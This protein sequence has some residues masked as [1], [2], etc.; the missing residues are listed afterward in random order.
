MARTLT[1]EQK[2]SLSR[3]SAMLPPGRRGVA[4]TQALGHDV[5]F[6]ADRRGSVMK[7]GVPVPETWQKRVLALFPKYL[8]VEFSD[9]HTK[10]W[11]W[12]DKI[13]IK[14]S[15]RPF[16]AVWPR[17]RGKSTH[18]E[19][20]VADLGARGARK[21]AIYVSETQ[22]QAD[23][24]IQ[25]IRAVLESQDFIKYFP[26]LGEPRVGK[27][28]SR[29]WRRSILTTDTG[30][31]VE[32]VGL[33]R[34]IRGHKIDWA[35]PD[36]ILF[37]DIDAKHDTPLSVKRKEGTIT[38]SILPSGATNCAVV[39]CQN[40]IHPDSIANK[41]SKI[42]SA[43]GSADYLA[44]RIISGPFP[45][46][47]NLKYEFQKRKGNWKWVITE[48]T[49]L[50]KG[51]PIKVCEKEINRSGPTAFEL[52][53][54]HDVDVDDPSALL[55][56]ED[57]TRTRVD[58]A[59]ELISVAVSVDPPASIGSCGIIGGGVAK[60]GKELHGFT[61]EDAT[62]PPGTKPNDWALAVLK[63]YH[64]IKADFIVCEANNGG[65]MVRSNIMNAKWLDDEG[66]VIVDGATITVEMVHASR[67]KRTRAEPVATATEQG[68]IH[69]VGFFPEL[70]K[71]WRKWVPGR[72]PSPDRLDAE[73]WLYVGLGVV[74]RL[75]RAGVW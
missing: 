47:D 67:G 9:P 56:A 16:I 39:F 70:E 41:L 54:Q 25:T 74:T 1:P 62:P 44:N 6:T 17:G 61:L 29:T 40:I 42:P 28:G 35:R 52:E 22:D 20:L 71:Q 33:D 38:T 65:E 55:A 48:G 8:W 21:Y 43:T 68:K 2:S 36:L 50:W 4:K 34:A 5:Y 24:H 66:E 49:S 23:K 53:S 57:F 69:H 58:K 13:D 59:P 11:E 31:T 7:R 30:F 18:A 46:V 73:V 72:S 26:R 45:A 14:S 37:D 51:F 64:R 32:A 12:V 19:L 63:C 75:K 10:L 3:I 27:H 15:P 60:V